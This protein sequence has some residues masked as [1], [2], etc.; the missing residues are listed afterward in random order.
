[1]VRREAKR[2]AVQKAPAP[3]GPFQPKPVH[4]RRQPQHGHQ[5]AKGNLRRGSF[6]SIR[7]CRDWPGSAHVSASRGAVPGHDFGAQ[8]PA[9]KPAAGA[10]S[11][12]AWRAA[13]RDRAKT[14]KPLQGYSSFPTRSA[15]ATPQAARQTPAACADASGNATRVRWDRMNGHGSGQTARYTRIGIN[16]I[17]GRG[18]IAFAHQRGIARGVEQEHSILAVH[19]AGDLKQVFRVEADFQALVGIGDD[20]LF[21]CRAAIG[22][23]SRTEPTCHLPTP[24]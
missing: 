18:V 3:F 1:M 17:Y 20:Q 14:A 16:D 8:L 23:R 24:A 6:S 9:Q 7:T 13:A 15:R 4:R 2:G 5:C 10:P 19:L 12:Q 11:R 22:G 21:L